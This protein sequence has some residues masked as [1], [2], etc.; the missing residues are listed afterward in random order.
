[1]TNPMQMRGLARR[2]KA[3]SIFFGAMGFLTFSPQKPAFPHHRIEVHSSEVQILQEGDKLCVLPNKAVSS[4][5]NKGTEYTEKE[6]TGQQDEEEE[7]AERIRQRSRKLLDGHVLSI[8]QANS[9]VLISSYFRQVILPQLNNYGLLRPAEPFYWTSYNEPPPSHH[10]H[11]HQ[12]HRRNQ[13]HLNDEELLLCIKFGYARGF[14]VPNV[15]QFFNNYTVFRSRVREEKPRI[16]LRDCYPG[17]YHGITKKGEPLY[18]DQPGR[19]DI[20]ALTG[21]DTEVLEDA[22]IYSYEYMQQVILPCCSL[23]AGRRIS[24]G[25]TI[26]DLDGVG[27]STFNSK[28]RGILSRMIRISQD[29]YPE[30]MENMYII[31]APF[32]FNAIWRF[33]KGLLDKATVEKIHV[34]PQRGESLRQEL[35][36]FIDEDS[37]PPFLLKGESE[38]MIKGPWTNPDVLAQLYNHYPYISSHLVDFPIAEQPPPN[39]N[40]MTSDKKALLP[41]SLQSSQRPTSPYSEEE[42]GERGGVAMEDRGSRMQRGLPNSTTESGYVSAAL[43]WCKSWLGGAGVCT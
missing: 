13:N 11:Q 6:P 42:D 21:H 17:R 33:V 37:M 10:G 7:S 31:R 25:V 36:K 29:Y 30:T 16:N 28:T 2:S 4:R 8:T 1:M 39:I 34:L 43:T 14:N 9:L 40:K 19:I 12:N 5:H 27:I 18:L 15:K 24:R 32:I 20:K 3:I 22:W 23:A 38:T 35:L 26:M 41:P